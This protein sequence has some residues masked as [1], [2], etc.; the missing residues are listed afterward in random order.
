MP[1]GATVASMLTESAR[2]HCS[3][4]PLLCPSVLIVSEGGAH[5]CAAVESGLE[6]D[7]FSAASRSFAYRAIIRPQR[8]PGYCDAQRSCGGAP[9]TLT[10][11]FN[12]PADDRLRLRAR[13]RRDESKRVERPRRGPR[14]RHAMNATTAPRPTAVIPAGDQRIDDS[15][16]IRIALLASR[17]PSPTGPADWLQAD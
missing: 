7:A 4:R 11:Q 5:G 9:R 12:R 15:L 2:V 17:Q 8:G 3:V 1:A 14:R 16:L 13:A 10:T 6:A